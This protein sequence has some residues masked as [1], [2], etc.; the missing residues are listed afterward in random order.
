MERL[1]SKAHLETLRRANACLIGFLQQFSDVAVVGTDSEVEALQLVEV[2]LQ[3][4]GV[5]LNDGLQNT[6]EL[7]VREEFARYRD[8]LVSL[9]RQLSVMQDSATACRSR[10]YSRQQ[11][12]Q[13]VRAWCGASRDTQ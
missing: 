2:T 3:S 5:L 10:L 1:N 8:N 12:L 9:R 4:V 6:E 7:S 11:H 13:A